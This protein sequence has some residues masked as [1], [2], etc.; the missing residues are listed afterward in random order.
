MVIKNTLETM[1]GKNPLNAY[2]EEVEK[3]IENE[4]KFLNKPLLD[5]G[6]GEDLD[7]DIP[8]RDVSEFEESDLDIEERDIPETDDLERDIPETDD[9]DK[10]LPV[11]QVPTPEDLD[12]EPV[13]L[14][15]IKVDR[16]SI[17]PPG[18]PESE[19]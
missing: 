12:C 18:T 11:P 10:D 6:M 16:C 9:L 3:P 14:G 1:S 19:M 7:L 13:A 5:S 8:E 4:E 15:F 2:V 17:A